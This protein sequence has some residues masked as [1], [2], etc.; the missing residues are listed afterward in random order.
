MLFSLLY[1]IFRK[2]LDVL[3]IDGLSIDQTAKHVYWTDAQRRRIEMV[4]YEGLNRRV[5][6]YEDLVT[7]RG[8]IVDFINGYCAELF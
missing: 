2:N 8:V 4:D 5:V 7:P 1:C 6:I 3:E